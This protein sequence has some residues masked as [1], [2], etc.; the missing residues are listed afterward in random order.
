[1]ARWIEVYRRKIG[2]RIHGAPVLPVEALRPGEGPLL[3]TVGARG[4]RAQVREFAARAGLAEGRDFLC[5]T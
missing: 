2:Q 5:V 1:L 4:A 3:V